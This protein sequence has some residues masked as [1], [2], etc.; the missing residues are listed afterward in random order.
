LGYPTPLRQYRGGELFRDVESEEGVFEI[1]NSNDQ[2]CYLKFAQGTDI[3]VGDVLS[4]G[5]SHP[6]T[7][8]DKWDVLY[9]VD[10]DYNVTHA[11]KTFF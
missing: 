6:C 8:F 10:E 4:F 1:T 9:K 2:H 3:R 5:I 7:A 11:L